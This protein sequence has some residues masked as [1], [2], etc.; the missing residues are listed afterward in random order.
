M[1]KTCLIKKNPILETV[2]PET[3]QSIA[4]LLSIPCHRGYQMSRHPFISVLLS[5]I[6]NASIVLSRS[7]FTPL[8]SMG[9]ERSEI[10]D[11]NSLHQVSIIITKVAYNTL[12]KLCIAQLK[13]TIHDFSCHENPYP[14]IFFRGKESTNSL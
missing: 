9:A 13:E 1:H 5:A 6:V 10:R 8:K 2:I 7:R 14:F 12:G 11:S 4:H 3:S